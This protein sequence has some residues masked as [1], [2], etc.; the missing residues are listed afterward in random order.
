[1]ESLKLQ[2]TKAKIHKTSGAEVQELVNW[3]SFISVNIMNV[4]GAN[5]NSNATGL[6]D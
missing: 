5:S 2:K 3:G 6:S 1:M 4:V